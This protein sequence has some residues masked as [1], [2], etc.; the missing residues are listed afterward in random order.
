MWVRALM[1]E[2]V[3]LSNT[4]SS[5]SLY[6]TIYSDG[7]QCSGDERP[8]QDV[9]NQK[10]SISAYDQLHHNFKIWLVGWYSMP[11]IPTYSKDWLQLSRCLIWRFPILNQVWP[12]WRLAPAVT[13]LNC[14]QTFNHGIRPRAPKDVVNLT[15]TQTFLILWSVIL[16]VLSVDRTKAPTHNIDCFPPVF[17]I[18]QWVLWDLIS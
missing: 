18:I 15:A 7:V 11:A 2:C 6:L 8:V 14:D 13:N 4:H 10:W 9:C 17:E 12:V 1:A 3:V 16:S 5:R